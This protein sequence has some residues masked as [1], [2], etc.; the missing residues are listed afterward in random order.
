MPVNTAALMADLEA[1]SPPGVVAEPTCTP[2]F[3][4]SVQFV[5]PPPRLSGDFHLQ[6]LP[7]TG[8]GDTFDFIRQSDTDESTG[9]VTL[10]YRNVFR[11]GVFT[12]EERAA[13][14]DALAAVQ[15]ADPFGVCVD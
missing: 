5:A 10:V 1:F 13:C 3:A 2:G 12:A 6:V 7:E 15:A 9:D 8:E 11:F 4:Y 14:L